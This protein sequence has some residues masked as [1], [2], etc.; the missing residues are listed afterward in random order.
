MSTVVVI[1]LLDVRTEEVEE[2]YLIGTHQLSWE[3]DAAVGVERALDPARRHIFVGY[4][5]DVDIIVH[6]GYIDEVTIDAVGNGVALD[7]SIFGNG[8]CLFLNFG[9]DGFVV[10]VM[11]PLTIV[12]VG[13]DQSEAPDVLFRQVDAA[14]FHDKALSVFLDAEYYIAIGVDV[15]LVVRTFHSHLCQFQAIGCLGLF[16]VGVNWVVEPINHLAVGNQEFVPL[17][18][19]A[20]PCPRGS[21]RDDVLDVDRLAVGGKDYTHEA[22]LFQ[23]VGKGCAIDNVAATARTDIVAQ[24]TFGLSEDD[25]ALAGLHWLNNA[26][27]LCK[28]RCGKR[29]C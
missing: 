2:I 3:V 20:H 15:V 18:G 5:T 23:V 21:T 4:A 17:D 11:A 28:Q 16:R 7:D 10:H 27:G 12:G 24:F 29:K 13:V 14:A 26:A 6:E 22:L 1:P 25:V 8:G 9:K 19:A